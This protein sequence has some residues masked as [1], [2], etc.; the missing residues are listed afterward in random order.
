MICPPFVGE[1]PE[2]GRNSG[3]WVE[4]HDAKGTPTFFRVLHDPLGSSAEI[5]SPDGTITREFGPPQDSTFEVLLPDEPGSKTLVLMG[6][7]DDPSSERSKR[8][9]EGAGA[10]EMARFDLADGSGAT[11]EPE[12]GL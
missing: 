8:N 10:H 7:Y 4:L 9:A 3:F 6:D 11:D 5:H 12:V 2:A 1:P